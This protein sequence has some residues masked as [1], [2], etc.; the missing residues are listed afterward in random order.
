VRCWRDK[1]AQNINIQ[2]GNNAAT[3][4]ST[5]GS[6]MSPLAS[7]L[8][9]GRSGSVVWDGR[10][11]NV[12]FWKRVL[13]TAEWTEYQQSGNGNVYPFTP[14]ANRLTVLTPSAYQVFQ[15]SGSTGTIAIRGSYTGIPTAIEARWNGGGWTTIDAAPANGMYSG[16]LTGQTGGQGTLEVR[17][18]NNPS[19]SQSVAYVG[20]GDVFLIAGQ[21][22]ASGRATNMQVYSGTSPLALLFGNDYVWKE[23]VDPTDSIVGQIDAVSNVAPDGTVYGSMWPLLATPFLA[24]QSVPLAFVPCAAGGTSITAWQPGAVHTNQTTLYGSMVARG[25]LTGCKAVLWWQGETDSDAGMSQATYNSNLDTLANAINADLGVKLMPC[26]LQNYTSGTAPNR[27]AIRAAIVEAWGDN[28][29]VLTGPDL[30]AIPSDDIY[31]LMS[32]A[33]LASA[34]ALWWSALQ[35][36]FSYA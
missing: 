16:S 20:V 13:T 14:T 21:S 5:P 2:I 30:S 10:I 23:M 15:R 19:V 33:H 12:A 8:E 24:S 35:A 31:H 22:N 36:A 26:K 7:N 4:T 1:A 28:T 29:N 11:D 34:A 27:D 18:V 9:I 17:F 25:L 32:N 3:T 6:V